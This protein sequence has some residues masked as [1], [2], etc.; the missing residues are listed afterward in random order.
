M[1]LEGASR[2]GAEF[3]AAMPNAD[4]C[5][6]YVWVPMLSSDNEPAARAS[7]QRFDERR[8]I[9][10]WD[11]DRR[12]SRR[13]AKALAINTRRS[14]VTGDEPAFAWDIYLAYAKGSSDVA[15]PD[16]WMHQLAVDHAPRLDAS[17]WRRRIDGLLAQA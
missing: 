2:A 6:Y 14:A 15:A 8:A 4:L 13:M 7:A 11:A 5:A 3:L 17:E 12:L 10:Y 9:H 16:F 1:C